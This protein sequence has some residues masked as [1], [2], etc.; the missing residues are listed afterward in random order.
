MPWMTMLNFLIRQNPKV[1]NE[2]RIFN[3]NC[4]LSS[5]SQMISNLIINVYL[6]LHL[7]NQKQFLTLANILQL[8]DS[9]FPAMNRW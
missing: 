5:Y 8:S 9:Y 1:A 4:P 7:D 6:I 2:K 3:C